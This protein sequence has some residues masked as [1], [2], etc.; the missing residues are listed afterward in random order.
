MYAAACSCSSSQTRSDKLCA[1]MRPA[2]REIALLFLKLGTIGFGGPAA[3]IA[4]MEAEVVRRR[5]WLSHEDFLDLL[6]A[7]NLI[8][9]PNSTEMAIH[10]GYR[11]AGFAGLVVAG[12][13]FILPAVL[14]VSVIAWFYV[15]Y[16]ALLR[17]DVIL[18][19]VKP[20]II[21]V[22]LQALWALSKTA[23]K[24]TLLAAVAVGSVVLSLAGVHELIVL[25]IAGVGCG[26]VGRVRQ[27][28]PALLSVELLPLFLFF[29]KVGSI[30]FG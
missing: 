14:I 8:P 10:I 1:A 12:T 4:L 23:V 19:S 26:I 20:V 29:L 25:L 3:H 11:R 6:G 13:C 24:T 7:T 17:L 21:M 15:H 27:K 28:S 16:G 18:R 30:L 9:G 5:G 2:L 22:V